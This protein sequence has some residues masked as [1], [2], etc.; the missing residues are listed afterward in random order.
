MDLASIYLDTNLWNRLLDQEVEPQPLLRDLLAEGA[1][2][3]VSSQALYELAR[4]F[5]KNSARAQE[6]FSYL[7]VYLDAGIIAA[8]DNP[9]QLQGEVRALH[10]R[11]DAVVAFYGQPEYKEMRAEVDKLAQ[12]VVDGRAQEFITGRAQFSKDTRSDQRAHFDARKDARDRLA[13]ITEQQLPTWLQSESL[14]PRGTAILAGQ[15]KRIYDDMSDE[16]AIATA[17]YLLRIPQSRISRGLVRAGLYY[18]W[19]FANRGS[20][21]RDLIDDVYHVLNASYCSVYATADSGQ[22][23][24]ASLLL[25][26]SVYVGFYD[27]KTPVGDWLVGQASSR[28]LWP[29][30]TPAPI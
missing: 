13:A 23:S 8:H 17:H 28:P 27:E 16:A 26:S 14:K 11:A 4:T 10:A 12:G 18:D 15:I 6:L 9:Q 20:N 5:E 25:P 19:R 29:L 7:K 21:P 24:Y 22:A 1:N 3:A 30:F 2:L